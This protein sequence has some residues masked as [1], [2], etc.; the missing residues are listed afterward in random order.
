V[1]TVLCRRGRLPVADIVQ[2]AFMAQ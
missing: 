1:V 2:N